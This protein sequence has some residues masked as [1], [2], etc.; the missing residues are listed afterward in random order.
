M[1]RDEVIIELGRPY[2]LGHNG[3]KTV[4]QFEKVWDDYIG[5]REPSSGV[6]VGSLPAIPFKGGFKVNLGPGGSITAA[7]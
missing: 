7:S 4:I 5:V 2:I 1:S 6:I 3:V